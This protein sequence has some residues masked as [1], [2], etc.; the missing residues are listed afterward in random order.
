MGLEVLGM[1]VVAIALLLYSAPAVVRAVN[2]AMPHPTSVHFRL[3]RPCFYRTRGLAHSQEA[4][5]ALGLQ[6]RNT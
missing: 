3:C 6:E 2:A 1:I 5:N 4:R